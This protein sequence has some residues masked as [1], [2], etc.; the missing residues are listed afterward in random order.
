MASLGV[1]AVRIIFKLLAK[2]SRFPLKNFTFLSEISFSYF[3]QA[4]I[5]E[6]KSLLYVSRLK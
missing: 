1:K 6:I 4:F 3:L 2:K 5:N